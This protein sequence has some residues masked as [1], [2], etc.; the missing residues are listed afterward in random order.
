VVP[1]RVRFGFPSLPFSTDK[2][3]K[4]RS[5]QRISA[6]IGVQSRGRIFCQNFR[7]AAWSFG[8]GTGLQ[9]LRQPTKGVP[10]YRVGGSA[11]WISRCSFILLS[12]NE[13]E[14]SAQPQT[15]SRLPSTQN[16]KLQNL[17]S[18]GVFSGA[19]LDVARHQAIRCSAVRKRPAL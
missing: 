8:W 19:G 16:G 13:Q 1:A 5:N 7:K 12:N 17:N 6:T 4:G 10:P 15:V 11:V 3:G 2:E 18:S 14:Q 9:N